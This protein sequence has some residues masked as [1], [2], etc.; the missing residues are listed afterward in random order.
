MKSAA[1]PPADNGDKRARERRKE[2]GLV[3]ILIEPPR[4]KREICGEKVGE[5]A[6]ASEGRR[7]GQEELKERGRV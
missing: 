2:G 4:I 1:A 3:P 6:M 5:A 7:K